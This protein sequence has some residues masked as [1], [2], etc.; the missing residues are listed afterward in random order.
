M[1]GLWEGWERVMGGLLEAQKGGQRG[2][3]FTFMRRLSDER[4][5]SSRNGIK[6]PSGQSSET[7]TPSSANTVAYSTAITP[8]PI[9]ATALGSSL[10]PPISVAVTMRDVTSNGKATPGDRKAGRQGREPVAM[11]TCLAIISTHSEG[12]HTRRVVAPGSAAACG[13]KEK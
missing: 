12:R 9:T 6:A 13:D 11:H 2:E 7:P 8:P 1:G 4:T 5:S 10:M 3:D